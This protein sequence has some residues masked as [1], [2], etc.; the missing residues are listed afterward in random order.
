MLKLR[1][2]E[3]VLSPQLKHAAKSRSIQSQTM[4]LSASVPPNM[5]LQQ[6]VNLLQARGCS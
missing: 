2:T 6:Y 4:R 1:A 3:M 5:G